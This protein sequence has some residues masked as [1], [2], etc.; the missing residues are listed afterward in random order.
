VVNNS[1]HNQKRRFG[2]L[3]F[4]RKAI[5][6]RAKKVSNE[7][8]RHAHKFLIKRWHNVQEVR[9]HVILWILVISSLITAS[10][11]QF[12]WYQCTYRTTAPASTGTYAEAVLGPVST[13][14]PLFASSSAEKSVAELL[15]SRLYS[16]DTTGHLNN[17]L[18]TSLEISS[19]TTKYTVKIRPD[20]LWHD[21]WQITAEDVVFTVN[22]IKD[23]AARTNI[24]GWDNITATKV[25]DTTIEFNLPATY[26]AFQHALTFPILPKHILAN[27]EPSKLREN[28]Y[29]SEPIGSGPFKLRLVQDVDSSTDR[30]VVHMIRN[31]S[32]Y[33]GAPKLAR[34]QIHVY[35]DHQAIINALKTGEVNAAADLS[36]DDISLLSD[37]KYTVTSTPIQSG[38]YAIFNT[39]SSILSDKIVRQAL[40]L[41]T[42]TKAIRQE[43]PVTM[44]VLDLPFTVNQLTVALPT[45]PAP[46]ANRAQ[47]LLD[48]AGWKLNGD[49]REKDGRQLRLSVITIQGREY[50]KALE[51]LASQWRKL[52]VMVDAQIIN[53]DISQNIAQ[54]IL[55][56]RN[57]DVL[58]YQLEIGGDPDVY[59]YW[60][61]S[62]ANT[63]GFNFSNYS[64]SVSDDALLSARTRLELSLRDAKYA[65]FARQWLNDVPAIGLYQPTMQYVH[66]HDLNTFDS[67]LP[68]VT[69]IDR[70]ASVRYWTVGSQYVFKTP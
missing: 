28:S 46:D 65:T 54:S 31:D 51:T 14:N 8:V 67:A 5:S 20:A 69:P 33:Q 66:I 12:M 7:T 3:T 42:N 36:V 62:Q 61:S 13:L 23:S 55:Q 26:A 1:E 53:S 40:Q 63:Q 48:Q 38:V 11:V 47:Q 45:A 17:D 50:E 35:K 19:E 57:F 15:F 29:S 60:H 39:T 37:T 10:G 70:Y 2:K 18:A 25:D 52:G 56:P 32:Y 6:V 44:P 59:A 16:Y 64:N 68:L 30:K 34:F 21:G 4:S 41:G 49:V 24:T 9:R 43:L 58:I 27:V 22:L